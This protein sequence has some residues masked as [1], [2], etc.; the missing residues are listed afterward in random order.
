MKTSKRTFEEAK[1]EIEIC[2]LPNPY[3]G[4]STSSNADIVPQLR[5]YL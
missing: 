2:P 3:L 1:G 5:Q 4:T